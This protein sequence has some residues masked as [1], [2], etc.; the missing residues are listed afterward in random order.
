MDLDEDHLDDSPWADG[1]LTGNVMGPFFY[2][3]TT[4]SGA[5]EALPFVAETAARRGLVCF[6]PQTRMLIPPDRSAR[7]LPS[8]REV[9]TI[10][11]AENAKTTGETKSRGWQLPFRRR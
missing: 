1:P 3:A 10:G 11:K 2:F 4:Y 8:E 6:D 5:H 7:R 9:A